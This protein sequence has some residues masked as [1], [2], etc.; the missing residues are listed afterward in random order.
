MHRRAFLL[1]AT[2]PFAIARAD[3]AQ[4][5]PPWRTFEVTTQVEIQGPPG[6]ARAWLP[7]AHAPAERYQRV[8]K[9][10]W[11]GS[12]ETLRAIRDEKTGTG[13]LLAEW[14]HGV[15]TRDV[16]LTLQVATR[17]RA[18]DWR[19]RTMRGAPAATL[20]RYM[21]STLAIRLDGL[22]RE[23]ARSITEAEA[24]DV[25]KARAIYEW[26]LADKRLGDSNVSFVRLA[27][28]SGVPAR[29]ICGI[30]VQPGDVTSAQQAR[31]EF[32][33]SRQGWVPVNPA[34]VR[35]EYDRRRLFGGWDANW[36]AFNEAHDVR[37][38][39]GAGGPLPLLM[40]P[41]AEVAGKRLDSLDANGFRYRITSREMT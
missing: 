23:I 29:L 19:D 25:A 4:D 1:T 2:A 13:I 15:A 14:P 35:G 37:L 6:R 8:V 34:G 12:A 9:Q 39:N 18:V 11:R 31:A 16:Q 17:D 10:S 20:R 22:A 24:D 26:V 3:G 33:A 30:R 21:Q 41:H 5:D 28:A 40:H 27:R 32:H 7:L 36:I 38:P